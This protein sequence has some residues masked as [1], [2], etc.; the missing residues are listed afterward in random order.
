MGN[1][2]PVLLAGLQFETPLKDP[3]LVKDII[4]TDLSD[5]FPIFIMDNNLKTANLPDK[6]TKI[7]RKINEKKYQ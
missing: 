4:K 2:T 6:V 1:N 3:Y 5:H 7:A